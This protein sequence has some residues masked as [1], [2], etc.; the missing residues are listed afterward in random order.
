MKILDLQKYE[1]TQLVGQPVK[2]EDAEGWIDIH[3]N[4]IVKVDGVVELIYGEL[5][6]AQCAGFQV[7]QAC[8]EI[9]YS[10]SQ[11]LARAQEG[12]PT[13]KGGGSLKGRIRT[14]DTKF[15][16]RPQRPLYGL[17]AG[18]SQFN[19]DYP[20]HYMSLEKMA[21]WL[22]ARYFE[23]N[24]VKALNHLDAMSVVREDSRI[25]GKGSLFTQGVIN[26][27]NILPY[28]FD[29]GNFPGAWSAM[30][31]YIKGMSGGDL[32]LPGL[33]ARLIPQ[34]RTYVLFD[35][36]GTLHGVSPAQGT[37][38]GAY[39]YSLVFYALALMKRVGTQ[40]EQMLKIRHSDMVKH[41]KRMGKK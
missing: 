35:G 20:L 1:P 16:F 17:P 32:L 15:G 25:G 21:P 22:Q 2:P 14:I 24:P 11:R 5:D 38:P 27:A 23:H 4:T 13:R 30:V 18:P 12:A 3:P 34:N 19:A 7:E 10:E 31:Y 26:K 9:K 40:H 28:H 41:R 29:S 6:M 39:R 37:V 36:Q 33:R 8:R